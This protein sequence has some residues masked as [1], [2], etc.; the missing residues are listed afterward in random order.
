MKEQS[1]IL[2]RLYLAGALIFL[3][4]LAVSF[5]LIWIQVREGDELM[6]QAEQTVVKQIEVEATR[7][8]IYAADG[9]PPRN[10]HAQIWDPHGCDDRFR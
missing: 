7:G 9:S 1:D 4:A 10:L 8:N 2:K 6:A 3:F 5:K